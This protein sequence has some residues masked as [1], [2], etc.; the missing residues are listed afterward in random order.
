MST[1]YEL[2]RTMPPSVSPDIDRIR[3]AV[4]AA[5]ARHGEPPAAK[6]YEGL[7]AVGAAN[8]ALATIAE[9][10]RQIA[11]AESHLPAAEARLRLEARASHG[12]WFLA[13][14]L[15]LAGIVIL[16]GQQVF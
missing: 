10:E 13:G 14:G 6:P 12:W 7:D 16:I 8:R 11:D 2:I 15:A 5:R 1:L 3:R 9:S 4:V